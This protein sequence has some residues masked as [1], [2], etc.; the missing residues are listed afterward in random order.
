M[1]ISAFK[2]WMP[3]ANAQC[4][5]Q[6]LKSECSGGMLMP[7][8]AFEM[9]LLRWNG[10]CLSE[11]S[12]SECSAG[13]Y[14]AHLSIW[15]LNALGEGPMPIWAFK[16]WI[17]RWNAQCPSEHSKSECSGGMSNANP[18]I[19]KLML[20]IEGPNVH[21][22]FRNLNVPVEC[23]MTFWAFEIWMFRWNAQCPYEHSQSPEFKCSAGMPNAH[24]C[25]R[26]NRTPVMSNAQI[27]AQCTSFCQLH[28]IHHSVAP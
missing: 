12:K 1:P 2:I 27:N 8:W 6:H 23:S 14:N 11:H 16:I 19:R 15:N 25:I 13:M 18:S 10:Y 20:R 28:T 9:W 3:R 17:P 4:P 5:S 21:L 7:I 26:H 22:C 24:L